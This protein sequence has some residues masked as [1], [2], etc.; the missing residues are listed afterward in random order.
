LRAEQLSLQANCCVVRSHWTD[1]AFCTAGIQSFL[2][3]ATASTRLCWRGWRC[4]DFFISLFI[5]L[6]TLLLLWCVLSGVRQRGIS[7]CLGFAPT[8]HAMIISRRMMQR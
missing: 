8:G 5:V 2:T 3:F 7:Y 1:V 6:P 4:G